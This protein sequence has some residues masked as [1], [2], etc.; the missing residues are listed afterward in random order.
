MFPHVR[1]LLVGDDGQH[2]PEIYAEFA[3]EHPQCV[4][5]IAI[6][7]LSEIEQFMAHGSFRGHGPRRAVDRTR[8]RARL[9]RVERLRTAG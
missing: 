7:S 8:A 6:R 5:G 4:A 2:D 1:W 3:R 9:V